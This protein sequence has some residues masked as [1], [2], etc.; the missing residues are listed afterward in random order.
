MNEKPKRKLGWRLLRW[1]LIGLAVLV[2]LAAVL[3]TEENWRAKRDWE[4]YQ[5]EAV[6]RGERLD[7]ASVI[8]PAVPDDQN[9][10]CAPI[11]AEALNAVQNQS[12][13]SPG[14]RDTNSVNRMDFSI[15]RGDSKLWP[16]NYGNWQTGKPLNLKE[17]QQYFRAFNQTADG[18]TN[19]FSVPPQPGTPAADV[20]LG[21]SGFDPALEELRQAAAL[22]NARLP[23]NYEDGF[24]AAGRL[25]PWLANIK[26]CGQFLQ[27][28]IVAE[29]E[30]G[31]ADKALD[32]IELFLRITDANRNSRFLI[33]HLVRIAMLAIVLEPIH[34][35]LAE[36][37]WSDAQLAELER[38][39][40][41]EDFLVDFDLAMNGEKICAI[42]AFE[43]QRITRE[44]KM[45]DD[46]LGTNK[47][48]TVSLRWMPSAYFYQNQL[49]FARMHREWIASL[50]D[51]TNRIVAPSALR[52]VLAAISARST[53]A[54]YKAQASM[55]LPPIAKSVM[56]FAMI[57]SQVDLARVACVLERYRLA[58]GVFPETLDALTPQ[59]I[60]KL[61]HD[62]I[63]G[64]PLHYRRTNDGQ[65]ILYSVGWDEKDDGG[66]IVF[67]KGGSVDREKGD[68]VWQYPA[69]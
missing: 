19:G 52:Q 64:Q 6:A 14:A 57:Q 1:G 30:N 4:N 28:R 65:F 25:F 12:I 36:H 61:P 22:P 24:E 63:N 18:K 20:L 66:Q 10:F 2:T 69:K 21:L 34:Q 27:L 16:T 35:G 45:V 39:L 54:L 49:F 31:Q 33:S 38:E 46:S 40:A 15:Y 8:P 47:I 43:K 53:P 41:N 29:L 60:A 13:Y 26:K 37:R 3:V 68:W 67:T 62:I 5:R 59:F 58:H 17:W 56:R 51:L 42:D 44:I 48:V 7:I 32:D 55:A 9:F 11:V 50:V 23:L